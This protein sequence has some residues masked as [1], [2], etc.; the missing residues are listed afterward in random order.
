MFC[1]GVLGLLTFGVICKRMAVVVNGATESVVRPEEA[2]TPWSF[3]FTNV[4]PDGIGRPSSVGAP[5]GYDVGGAKGVLLRP[6][7]MYSLTLIGP[8]PILTSFTFFAVQ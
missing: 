3:L 2:F 5:V 8:P 6:S 7:L 1:R 4:Q